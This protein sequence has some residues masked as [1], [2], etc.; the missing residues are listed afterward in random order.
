[1]KVLGT[2]MRPRASYGED[3]VF[4]VEI[5]LL[6]I[7]KIANKAGYRDWSSDD[8]KKLLRPGMEY[9]I[10][11]GYDFRGEIVDA[12]KKMTEAHTR[13]AASATTMARF[14][15]LIQQQEPQA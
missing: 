10:D 9:P 7:Q 12:V 14:A 6:E 11:E 4:I 1:M 5:S 2:A 15:G 8:T 3:E 13:F